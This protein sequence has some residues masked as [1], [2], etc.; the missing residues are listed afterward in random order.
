MTFIVITILLV[1]F[2]YSVVASEDPAGDYC[3]IRPSGQCLG[4][5]A[6]YGSTFDDLGMSK[7]DLGAQCEGDFRE[8]DS[9]QTIDQCQIGCCVFLSGSEWR[10]DYPVGRKICRQAA[11]GGVFFFDS[12]IQNFQACQAQFVESDFTVYFNVVDESN[13]QISL[14]TSTSYVQKVG[15]PDRCTFVSI[16]GNP[17][18]NYGVDCDESGQLGYGT[19][20]VHA[21]SNEGGI[22]RMF[23]GEEPFGRNINVPSPD[24][25][26]VYQLQM[27]EDSISETMTL[28]GRILQYE[29]VGDNYEPTDTPVP[30]ALVIVR[31]SNIQNSTTSTG[32][33]II[34]NIPLEENQE[35]L[36]LTISASGFSLA[37]YV[38]EELTDGTENLEN[39]YLVPAQE[40]PVG[41]VCCPSSFGGCSDGTSGNTCYVGM[42]EYGT[43]C[44]GN[45]P[46]E[47][48]N[49]PPAF[50]CADTLLCPENSRQDIQCGGQACSSPCRP[51]VQCGLEQQI[52]GVCQC[53]DEFYESGYCCN[54]GAGSGEHSTEVCESLGNRVTGLVLAKGRQDSRYSPRAGA[55]VSFSD[56]STGRLFSTDTSSDGNFSIRLPPGEYHGNAFLSGFR[57]PAYRRI[58]VTEISHSIITSPY[59]PL[60]SPFTYDN[61]TAV[62][63]RINDTGVLESIPDFLLP[64]DS[65]N[66]IFV[67]NFDIPACDFNSPDVYSIRS[68]SANHIQGQEKIKLTWDID[69]CLELSHFRIQRRRITKTESSESVGEFVDIAQVPASANNEYIDVNVQWSEYTKSYRGLPILNTAKGGNLF[70]SRTLGSD[71]WVENVYEY[72]IQPHFSNVGAGNEYSIPQITMGNSVCEGRTSP[73]T[74]EFCAY[75]VERSSIP[76]EEI[77]A[78]STYHN[79][80]AKLQ[81]TRT[82]R[83]SCDANNTL[84]WT[85]TSGSPNCYNENSGIFD[86][87]SG[88][89]IYLSPSCFG[90]DNTGETVCRHRDICGALSFENSGPF[91]MLERLSLDNNFCYG[92]R[93]GS[94]FERACVLQPYRSTSNK[95]MYCE[96][97]VDCSSYTS[98]QSCEID[99]CMVGYNSRGGQLTCE[100][101][102]TSLEGAGEGLCI[103]AEVRPS[104][105]F[106]GLASRENLPFSV[107]IG[108]SNELCSQL[109]NCFSSA[110]VGCRD[111]EEIAGLCGNYNTKNEC[112][113]SSGRNITIAYPKPE[114]FNE[115]VNDPEW[116]EVKLS[117]GGITSEY[118][119][120]YNYSQDGCGIGLCA[121][122]YVNNNCIRDANANNFRDGDEITFAGDI[123]DNNPPVMYLNS[124]TMFSTQNKVLRLFS[125]KPLL[126]HNLDFEDNRF[127]F[128]Y[129]FSKEDNCCPHLPGEPQEMLPPF[130]TQ[131]QNSFGSVTRHEI[132]INVVENT[133][134]QNSGDGA[135]YFRYLAQDNNLNIA[136]LESIMII[137]DTEPPKYEI[138]VREDIVAN[139]PHSTRL[140]FEV[141]S[142]GRDPVT[143][144]DTE[145]MKCDFSLKPVSTLSSGVDE[146]VITPPKDSFSQ[147]FVLEYVVP[148]GLYGFHLKCEDGAG[149]IND[150]HWGASDP[151][152]RVR[153]D[154]QDNLNIINPPDGGAIGS[155][156]DVL[157]EVHTDIPSSCF[158]S[159]PILDGGTEV[160]DLTSTNDDLVHTFK[161]PFLFNNRQELINGGEIIFDSAYN[162]N[163]VV[164]CTEDVAF[165]VNDKTQ[166]CTPGLNECP[167]GGSCKY[168]VVTQDIT[169]GIDKTA[170]ITTTHFTGYRSGLDEYSQINDRRQT[171]TRG[172]SAEGYRYD[173]QYFFNNNVTIELGCEDPAIDSNFP[174]I[175]AGCNDESITYCVQ[176]VSLFSNT[177]CTPATTYTGK[178]EREN[179][180]VLCFYS[181]DNVGNGNLENTTCKHFY[182]RK[183][184]PEADL[185][186]AT[187]IVFGNRYYV[188]SQDAVFEG[189]II[190][191][192]I[193][194]FKVDLVRSDAV[195]RQILNT[196]SEITPNGYVQNT[197]SATTSFSAPLERL[198]RLRNGLG[199]NILEL[200]VRDRF[201]NSALKS[202]LFYYDEFEPVMRHYAIN[203]EINTKEVH[204]DTNLEIDL[205]LDDVFWTNELR[206]V[207]AR[208]TSVSTSQYS[209]SY[210]SGEILLNDYVLIPNQPHTPG[211]NISSR[212]VEL[213]DEMFYSGTGLGLSAGISSLDEIAQWK[214][215]SFEIVPESEGLLRNIGIGEY[216][217][218]ILAEDP[219]GQT[220]YEVISFNVTDPNPVRILLESPG[221]VLNAQGYENKRV[222][223]TNDVNQVFIAETDAPAFCYF[224]L[225]T[226]PSFNRPMAYDTNTRTLHTFTLSDFEP[227]DRIV[228]PFV[229]SCEKH[230]GDLV[231]EQYLL[232][233]DRQSMRLNIEMDRGTTI[234]QAR[235][236]RD[237]IIQHSLAYSSPISNNLNPLI[238]VEDESSKRI[239]CEYNCVSPN[240]VCPS[241]SGVF[242]PSSQF[243]LAESRQ[244]NFADSFGATPGLPYA[245]GDYMY[246]IICQDEA[247]NYGR[248]KDLVISVRDNRAP[249]RLRIMEDGDSIRPRNNEIIFS[250]E[251][252]EIEFKVSTNMLTFCRIRFSNGQVRDMSEYASLSHSKSINATDLGFNVG[253][254]SYTYECELSSDRSISDSTFPISFSISSD[255]EELTNGSIQQ[256]YTRNTYLPI[257][258]TGFSSSYRYL[259][260]SLTDENLDD[261]QIS[262]NV[263][264]L[265]LSDAEASS[266]VYIR[267][268]DEFGRKTNIVNFTL[269]NE[270]VV[271]ESAQM[272]SLDEGML[273]VAADS[274]E[275][276]ER[277]NYYV[278]ETLVFPMINISEGGH[279]DLL[280]YVNGQ[281]V[282]T[283]SSGVSRGNVVAHSDSLISLP[284]NIQSGINDVFFWIRKTEADDRFVQFTINRDGNP[285]EIVSVSPRFITEDRILNVSL[286]SPAFCNIVYP[287]ASG[288]RQNRQSSVGAS[289]HH[290]FTLDDMRLPLRR[291]EATQVSISCNTRRDVST[292]QQHLMQLDAIPPRILDITSDNSIKELGPDG[293]NFTVV[294]DEDAHIIA[295]VDQYARC[296][297]VDSE[298]IKH[299][300]A[301]YFLH[302]LYPH[303]SLPSNEGET[304]SYTIVCEDEAGHKTPRSVEISVFKDTSLPLHIHDIYPDNM[305]NERN[306]E[307][308]VYTFRDAS[309]TIDVASRDDAQANIFFRVVDA[310]SNVFNPSLTMQK[311]LVGH[312]YRHSVQVSTMTDR[313]MGLRPGVLYAARVRCSPAGVYLGQIEGSEETFNFMFSSHAD[314]RPQI[315]IR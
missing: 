169:F 230:G 210:D 142:T 87:S 35:S 159:W 34:S 109:G 102:N 278:K 31:G 79:R 183:T 60:T 47:V 139:D 301:D 268:V 148:D 184:P 255:S 12:S 261:Y 227:F 128:R 49:L 192:Y 293:Y 229:I 55:T 281:S 241:S 300:F 221:P 43:L 236:L 10:Y 212:I 14:D 152:L 275:A 145:R 263:N 98:Q 86:S 304:D 164:S 213:I 5:Y 284:L 114:D 312:R 222:V 18:Y 155:A 177:V 1:L 72:R 39:I 199:P 121:W 126:A 232:M 20:L 248:A 201:D 156:Q 291:H 138:S 228:V 82:L 63:H 118:D 153:A 294:R 211:G 16:P 220:L 274:F 168:K 223:I 96:E 101:I 243:R 189:E 44:S 226:T 314:P 93:A 234:S 172:T 206:N 76:I 235:R 90:P 186:I 130:F 215:Y 251:R 77:L 94:R 2:S 27:E 303:T 59:R 280:V 57:P 46:F 85:Q 127:G 289:L 191:D 71:G 182:I 99:N 120:F 171:D 173:G 64:E 122:D 253:T 197:L 262:Y 231:A 194:Y 6:D 3:C 295:S 113:G 185:S 8:S 233:F 193:D 9:C 37:G 313:R 195:V 296:E 200:R 42:G 106:C 299:P 207:R 144:T 252:E 54:A 107:N 276:Q 258:I 158:I 287:S 74:N 117:C 84:Q 132:A 97:I 112:L 11:T 110:E 51:Q 269:S 257:L 250:D 259:E 264:S 306:P 305:T 175:R 290:K 67:M 115:G 302:N 273:G 265:T 17:N 311:T 256:V 240:S 150:T 15:E 135:Y 249:Q 141:V 214:K 279:K 137:V 277:Q 50:C 62:L 40:T 119:P 78:S 111:C 266:T 163:Y 88:D 45:S 219:F 267:A 217:I 125:N 32:E 48:C 196:A 161:K 160:Q 310:I 75:D 91:G 209:S 30:N 26:N 68:A 270:T 271:L 157:F 80:L 165:C 124:D 7:V 21:V 52:N 131:T 247:G 176:D 180:F 187:D 53:G 178:I 56:V 151:A 308:E 174:S 297:F 260:Y 190:G 286:S 108:W 143:G 149:N 129:C 218:E 140:T 246:E 167:N 13:D 315:I 116:A 38:V 92:Q 41:Q 66:N 147:S 244:F 100:W 179:S 133:F 136:R 146:P 309:C 242:S 282:T 162:N 73:L 83:V 225:G 181:T 28:R 245:F 285:P 70:E 104:E 81:G 24:G 25:T 203:G 272:V 134:I 307:I 254:F 69:D 89:S 239:S 238:T 288:S 224:D 204:Y 283:S 36:T 208:M 23:R 33:F 58:S 198:T 205:I 170:P 166:E 298:G 237:H 292:V 105:N 22:T 154:K 4:P 29:L 123:T 188:D 202:I 103:P 61:T 19:Y 95:C 65:N 216:A